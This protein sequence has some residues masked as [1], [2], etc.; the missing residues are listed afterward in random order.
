MT[1]DQPWTIQRS[2][3]PSSYIDLFKAICNLF[4]QISFCTFVYPGLV[5]AYL[6]QGARLIVDQEAVLSQV[7]YNSIPGP[8]NGPLFW[9]M[10]VFAV[11]ATVNIQQPNIKDQSSTS[12]CLAHRLA[13]LDHR[14]VLLDP[15]SHKF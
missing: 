4:S 10:F 13:S 15:T 14:D 8:V 11:L 5:L 2:L 6:G 1:F 9:I 12:V 7:F 3:H